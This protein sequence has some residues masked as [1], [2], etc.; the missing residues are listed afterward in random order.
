MRFPSTATTWESH[1]NRAIP[2]YGEKDDSVI[3]PLRSVIEE[4]QIS[5][6]RY[7]RIKRERVRD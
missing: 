1:R 6:D 2:R 7:I 5:P 3:I 4:S